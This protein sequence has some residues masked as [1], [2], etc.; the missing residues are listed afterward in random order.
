LTEGYK[1][2]RNVAS[3]GNS[4]PAA[5]LLAK[6]WLRRLSRNPLRYSVQVHVDQN[7]DEIK[8]FWGTTLG[9]EPT[10]INLQRKSNSNRLSGRT[11][12]SEY[13]VLTVAAG[14][15]YLRARLQAWMECIQDEWACADT[16][17]RVGA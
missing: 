3:I 16:L 15:T 6:T 5:V 14:D 12:R 11:W 17:D 4:D 9:V 7:L 8:R 1:R 13:G 10:S 2:S